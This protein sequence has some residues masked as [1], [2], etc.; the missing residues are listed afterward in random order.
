MS[1]EGE[2]G[3][4]GP[5]PTTRDRILGCWL[6]KAVGGTLGQTFE[7][8]EGPLSADFYYPVPEGMV[9][10]DDLDLQVLYAIVLSDMAE[11][12]V[13]SQVLAQAWQDHVSFP[14]NEYGVG[15]RN[16]AEGI[17]PPFTGSFDNWF[18]HGE[19]AAIRSEL[20]A[21]LAHGD[22]D[23]ASAYAEADACFDH[24]GDGVFAAQFLAR[25]QTLAFTESDPDVLLDRALAGIPVDSDVHSAVQAT[26]GWV[27]EGLD[28]REVRARIM[29][30]YG[31]SDFTDVRP[32]TAFVVLGWLAGQDFAERICITN[33]C[34]QDCDSSTASIGALLGIL[35]PGGIPEP[36]LQPIGRELILNP[37]VTGINPPATI[38]DLTD[39]VIELGDRLGGRSPAPNDE[40]F[41]SAAY[42]IPVEIAWYNTGFGK[43]DVRDHTELPPVGASLPVGLNWTA[44]SLPGTWTTWARQAF[45]DRILFVRYRVDTRGRRSLRL[46]VNATEHF[47]VWWDGGFL[48]AAQGTQF[49]FPA[50]HMPPVGQYVDLQ[51]AEDEHELIVA[52]K[53]PPETRDTAEWV[54]AIVERPGFMWIPNV[55]R[56]AARTSPQETQRKD[57]DVP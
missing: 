22:P 23:L 31:N 50:P 48:H 45:E 4:A 17:R 34:G 38:D 8:L 35:D 40:L 55:F 21:C 53:V 52:I 32:N 41:D 14:W 19:G 29:A 10:N 7:G 2:A 28:W 11:P 56:P 12:R 42:S 15:Q 51:V 46:M 20:W 36:W 5:G 27:A 37:E 30:R 25:L 9:P 24:A 3:L 49:M 47:R 54:T 6:G 26:R 57:N 1:P 43:W 13:D 18:T 39:L 16:F 33:N 44:A